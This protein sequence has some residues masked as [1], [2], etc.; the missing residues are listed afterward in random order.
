MQTFPEDKGR[1]NTTTSP[2]QASVGCRQ[3]SYA[4]SPRLKDFIWRPMTT[5]RGAGVGKPPRNEAGACMG[6]QVVEPAPRPAGLGVDR[7]ELAGALEGRSHGGAPRLFR[8]APAR[9]KRA[10][11]KKRPV[12]VSGRALGLRCYSVQSGGGRR[13]KPP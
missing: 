9:P 11:T 12:G 7:R 6:C 4:T 1:G 2:G 5:A 8:G 13:M 3:P 10:A